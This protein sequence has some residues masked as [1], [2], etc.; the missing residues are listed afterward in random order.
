MSRREKDFPRR[1]SVE[2]I[3]SKIQNGFDYYSV[4][5]TA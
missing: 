2:E 3:A 5:A 4:S 1:Q